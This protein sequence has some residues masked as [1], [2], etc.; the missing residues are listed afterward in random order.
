LI[1]KDH[2]KL[3]NSVKNIRK[4]ILQMAYHGGSSSAH[5]GGALSLA[6]I[7]TVIFGTVANFKKDNKNFR[8]S[9]ILSKGHACLAYYASLIE[10]GFIDE[11][12]MKKFE[13]DESILMGHPIKNL[14]KFIDFST[15]SLGIGLSIGVGLCI[16]M[17]KRKLNNNVYVIIGDGECNE[18]IIWEAAMSASHFKLD[19]LKVIL[20]LNS[21]QQT[22]STNNIMNTNDLSKKWESFNWDVQSVDGHSTKEIYE[23]LIYKKNDK[24]KIL[25]AKTTKGK[26]ISF[27]ENDNQW[28]HSILTK[29]KYE[30]ALKELA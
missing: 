1:S 15:G 18:G 24:P 4:K 10:Y 6:E 13:S 19:N 23:N 7:V 22:G 3:E 12:E 21:Y 5:I 9:F 16:G 26:G 28:H 14:E 29:Q 27:I 25:I 11:S 8:D 20:D 30:Q 17:K 2:S